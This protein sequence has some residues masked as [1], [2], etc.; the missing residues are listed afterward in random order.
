MN[1]E[2]HHLTTDSPSPFG[3]PV[4]SVVLFVLAQRRVLVIRSPG[5]FHYSLVVS[6]LRGLGEVRR[7]RRC[8]RLVFHFLVFAHRHGGSLLDRGGT[9]LFSIFGLRRLCSPFGGSFRVVVFLVFVLVA[10]IVL[11]ILFGSGDA[12]GPPPVAIL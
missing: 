6:L 8:Q 10:V 2:Q 9:V 1:K 4:G 7:R 5:L 3:T 12:A 11:V